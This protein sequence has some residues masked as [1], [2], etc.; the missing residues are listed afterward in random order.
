MI[1]KVESLSK[2]LVICTQYF[3]ACW[4]VLTTLLCPSKYDS[5]PCI[6][7]GVWKL[8]MWP[9]ERVLEEPKILCVVQIFPNTF[10]HVVK[11]GLEGSILSYVVLPEQIIV[12]IAD[13]SLG[14]VLTPL[15][16][17]ELEI[18]TPF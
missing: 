8:G 1:S 10:V 9:L 14:L 4:N 16:H 12:L 3:V 5:S 2:I 6:D 13:P 17:I 15:L 18:L 11:L 7:L